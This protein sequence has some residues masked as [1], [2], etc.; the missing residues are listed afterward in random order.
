M[1]KQRAVDRLKRISFYMIQRTSNCQL[2]VGLNIMSCHLFPMGVVYSAR[3]A[4]VF[5]GVV[6]GSFFSFSFGGGED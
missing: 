1:A 4:K 5:I 2:H 6:F 3:G